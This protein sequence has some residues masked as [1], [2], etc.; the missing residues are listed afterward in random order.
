MENPNKLNDT[1]TLWFHSNDDVNWDLDSYKKID[2]FNTIEEFWNIFYFFNETI[3]SNSMIFLMK[4]DIKPMWEDQQNINGGCWSFKILKKDIYK[5]WCELCIAV[6]GANVTND[7]ENYNTINGISISPKK[8]F[9]IIK[10]WSNNSKNS[11]N[12]LL[13]KKIPYIFINSSIYKAHN[14]KM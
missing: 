4:N 7:L 5:C 8:T 13:S 6:L 2:S 9:S 14:Y 11:D 12:S 10:I 3:V 1:W